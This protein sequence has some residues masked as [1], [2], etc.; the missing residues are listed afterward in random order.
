MH[1]TL[2]SIDGSQED[3]RRTAA[4]LYGDLYGSTPHIEYRRRYEKLTGELLVEPP[5]LP[6]VAEGVASD[7]VDIDTVIEQAEVV[8]IGMI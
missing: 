5:P 3:S 7:P 2:W 4:R 8:S 6:L 1:Y